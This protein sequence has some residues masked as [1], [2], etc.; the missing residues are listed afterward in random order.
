MKTTQA[1]TTK[2]T[3]RKGFTLT[4][5]ITVLASIALMIVVS[6]PP[7]MGHLYKTRSSAAE[8][9]SWRVLVALQSVTSSAQATVGLDKNTSYPIGMTLEDINDAVGSYIGDERIG[10]NITTA[11]EI[12]DLTITP[13]GQVAAFTYLTSTGTPITY[14]QTPHFQT[15]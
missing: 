7:L 10:D 14:T 2:A 8:L 1:T 12:T 9:E 13:R 5:L 3:G 15:Y 11:S 6:A 4:E